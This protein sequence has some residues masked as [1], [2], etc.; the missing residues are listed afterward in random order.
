MRIQSTERLKSEF[1]AFGTSLTIAATLFS[2]GLLPFLAYD[3]IYDHWDIGLFQRLWTT[4]FISLAI[5]LLL[6][7]EMP[8]IKRI[9]IDRDGLMLT[10][11]FIGTWTTI[12]WNNLDGYKTTIHLTR[13]GLVRELTLVSNGKEI[14]HISSLYQKNY[15]EISML[16]S[17]NLRKI[18]E[19]NF[20]WWDFVKRRVS[21]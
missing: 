4:F 7:V 5:P 16:V 20:R 9:E 3:W 13:G 21:K 17:R 11:P 10:N 12:S 6:R 8:K 2:I 15:G 1:D 14:F 18:A 19:K